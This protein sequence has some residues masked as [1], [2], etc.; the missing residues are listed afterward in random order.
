MVNS[1]FIARFI[2][3][4]KFIKLN[5]KNYYFLAD[6]QLTY[7]YHLKFLL[8]AMAEGNRAAV[9]A[10]PNPAM[11]EIRALVVKL[12]AANFAAANMP[13]IAFLAAAN[14]LSGHS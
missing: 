1:Y 2:K 10:G 7:I 3:T 9:V 6:N 4:I 14:H 5:L 13:R 11:A 12:A 8:P